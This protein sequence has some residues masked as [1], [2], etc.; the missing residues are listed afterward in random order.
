MAEFHRLSPLF[1]R[2]EVAVRAGQTVL[3]APHL[4]LDVQLFAADLA[5]GVGDVA[6]GSDVG[7]IVRSI[8]TRS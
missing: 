1:P 8:V 6:T 3:S 7:K 4:E 2:F 5:S